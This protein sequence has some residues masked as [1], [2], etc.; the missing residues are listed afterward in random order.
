MFGY[1]YKVLTVKYATT[2]IMDPKAK[3]AH[4]INRNQFMN[5]KMMN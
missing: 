3:I 4:F 2:S 1:Y 5:H